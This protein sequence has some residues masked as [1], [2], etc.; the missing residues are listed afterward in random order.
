MQWQARIQSYEKLTGF[1][2]SLFV[3]G[4]GRVVGT[5]IIGNDYRVKSKYYGGYPATYLRRMRS[6]FRDKQKVLH[7][8]SGQVDL[9]QMPGDGH[10]RVAQPFGFRPHR[11]GRAAFPHPALPESNPRHARTP[12]QG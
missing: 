4:D 8:F 7:L 3:A 11:S 10:G 5:W 12:A 9:D 2:G 6:L 1:P